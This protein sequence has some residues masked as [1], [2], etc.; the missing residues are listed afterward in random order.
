MQN[1]VLQKDI[2]DLVFN[3]TLPI[4]K[5]IERYVAQKIWPCVDLVIGNNDNKFDL[6]FL[7]N[8]KFITVEVKFDNKYHI[9]G[10]F[11]IECTS[12]GKP[13]GIDTT[14]SDFW[15]QVDKD[16]NFYCI[17]TRILKELCNNKRKIQSGCKDSGNE[18][19][20]IWDQEFFNHSINFYEFLLK[21]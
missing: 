8:V 11:F 19:Y 13:S 15:I 21:R 20:L 12:Y 1:W 2:T 7:K 5:K 14:K 16:L 10:N 9:T 17:E 4:G 18:G 3:E 6:I